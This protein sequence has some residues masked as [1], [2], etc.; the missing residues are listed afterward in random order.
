MEIETFKTNIRKKYIILICQHA[1]F[2]VFS[3]SNIVLVLCCVPVWILQ[4]VH[5]LFHQAAWESCI[6]LFNIVTI[7]T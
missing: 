1:F 7:F 3:K 5:L 4:I 2:N 6:N